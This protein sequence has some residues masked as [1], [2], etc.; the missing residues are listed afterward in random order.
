MPRQKIRFLRTIFAGSLVAGCATQ[1]APRPE[2]NAT[3]VQAEST[4]RDSVLFLLQRAPV[5]SV[6][7]HRGG[8]VILLPMREVE[9]YYSQWPLSSEVERFRSSI[10]EQFEER[11]WVRLGEGQLED[12]LATRLLQRGRAAI[13]YPS[14]GRHLIPWVRT[15]VE[16]QIVSNTT[17]RD[18]VFYLP[19]GRL[20]IRV[21][22]GTT[23]SH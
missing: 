10:S 8:A 13:R 21:P 3:L 18:R 1:A 19:D 12:I 16:R 14:G 6:V 20:L 4:S 5:D 11:G 15:A 22:D 2:A 7:L 17:I 23:L 9:A